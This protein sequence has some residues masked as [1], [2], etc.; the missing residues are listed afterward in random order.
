MQSLQGTDQAVKYLTNTLGTINS[1]AVNLSSA[2]SKE[3]F[4]Q[5][6]GLF[7]TAP[8]IGWD[9]VFRLLSVWLAVA[10]RMQYAWAMQPNKSTAEMFV[11]LLNEMVDHASKFIAAAR[12]HAASDADGR[13]PA[14]EKMYES[15]RNLVQNSMNVREV[16]DINQRKRFL[17]MA[18]VWDAVKDATL[19][20]DRHCNLDV[21]RLEECRTAYMSRLRMLRQRVEDVLSYTVDSPA[22]GVPRTE[23]FSLHP[24]QAHL[25]APE[26]Y[27]V[28]PTQQLIERFVSTSDDATKKTLALTLRKTFEKEA[29]S[30]VHKRLVEMF[31]DVDAVASLL[32]NMTATDS[33]KRA[34]L[35]RRVRNME[36]ACRRT[37]QET[38]FATAAPAPPAMLAQGPE[39]Q[40]NAEAGPKPMTGGGNGNGE[41]RSLGGG[42]GEVDRAIMEAQVNRDIERIRNGVRRMHAGVKGSILKL[43]L[44]S[45]P[46]DG[47]FA[48]YFHD[49][50]M[51]RLTRV[52]A[53]LDEHIKLYMVSDLTA[54]D[55]TVLQRAEHSRKLEL[56]RTSTI[57]TSDVVKYK[58][59]DTSVNLMYLLKGVRLVLQVGAMY[60]A[61]KIFVEGYVTTTVVDKKDP[62]ELTRMLYMFMCMDATLQLLI[63]LIL[64]LLSY[65]NKRPENTFI[66]D[67]DFLTTFLAEY[68]VTTVATFVLGS[69]FAKLM[70]VKRYFEYPKQGTVTTRAYRDI[71]I[72]V[73]AVMFAIPFFVL[74]R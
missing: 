6:L 24:V 38:S 69:V 58:F 15:T 3:L 21:G 51:P 74:F 33:E 43:A 25:F 22:L 53:S 45:A 11:S 23:A 52:V 72:G 71:M 19:G 17:G 29:L 62:P 40:M 2:M 59:A 20:E 12:A 70:R 4:Q 73:C 49:L 65:A 39:E 13:L 50:V 60:L 5:W 9:A 26:T 56:M 64:V 16:A 28:L 55:D 10:K 63:L 36:W 27:A 31:E 7:Q 68:F 32:R 42:G 66:V 67:D 18:R 8:S 47:A 41:K 1:V 46:R 30:E 35:D 57:N 14:M 48:I 37:W 54:E 44:L 34:K 61:Q